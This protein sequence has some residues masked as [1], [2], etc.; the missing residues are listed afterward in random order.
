MRKIIACVVAF[1][2]AAKKPSPMSQPGGGFPL[3]ASDP[4]KRT[5]SPVSPV[6]VG[7]K[8]CGRTA[9]PS[10]RARLSLLARVGKE[11]DARLSRLLHYRLH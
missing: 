6:K 5:I 11:N 7:M 3:S 4:A 9:D 1:T 8:R 2:P 10:T